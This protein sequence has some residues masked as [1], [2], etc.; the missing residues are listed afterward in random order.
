MLEVERPWR[1]LEKYR[2]DRLAEALYEAELAERFLKNGLLRNAAAKAFQ[3]VKAYLASEAAGRREVVAEAYPGV[4]STRRGRK[5]ARADWIIAAMPTNKMKEVAQLLGDRE[6]E[7][8]VEKALDLHEF[9]YNG[10]DHV[11]RYA[12]REVVE[13]DIADVVEFVRRRVGQQPHTN[14][15]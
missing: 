3:A 7:L 11:A 15:D 1:D 5:V 6:L 10:L 12:S 8:A 14:A 2:K 13:K 4:K 9:Q